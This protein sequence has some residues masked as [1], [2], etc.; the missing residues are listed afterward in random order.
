M[1]CGKAANIIFIVF[2]M[3][4]TR[5]HNLPLSRGTFGFARPVLELTIYRGEHANHYTTNAVLYNW[6]LFAAK[7]TA[8]RSKSKNC[9]DRNQDNVSK[10]VHVYHTGARGTDLP[11][12][13]F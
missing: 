8:L 2:G 4:G 7:H 10:G 1:L 6:Y 9:L 11:P 5:T 13:F 3:A 12:P